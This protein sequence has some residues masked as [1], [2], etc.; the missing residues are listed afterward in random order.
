MREQGLQAAQPRRKARTTAVADDPD[1]RPDLVRRDFTAQM[2]GTKWVSDI[3]YIRTW[4]G[5]VYLATVPGC[6]TKKVV[7]WAMAD[8]MRTDLVREAIDTAT[9]RCPHRREGEPYFIPTGAASTRP[10]SSPTT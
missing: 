3:T 2:P 9:R 1:E 4:A 5:F 8:H 7:G 6:C 10:S